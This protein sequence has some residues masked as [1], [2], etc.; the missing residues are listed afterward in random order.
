M[1]AGEHGAGLSRPQRLAAT[2]AVGLLLA[3][4]ALAAAQRWQEKRHPE[5]AR[6]KPPP[7]VEVLEL[8]A[9]P[10]GLA[11]AY[12]G[13]VEADSRAVVS[14]RLTARLVTVHHREG[15]AV[16]AGE[17]LLMLDDAELRREAERLRAVAERLA[18]ELEIAARQLER[19]RELHA[20][21]LIPDRTLDESLQRARTLEAQEREN[22]AALRLVDT[23]LGYA[24]ERAPFDGIVQRN[25]LHEGELAAIGQPLIELVSSAALKA[26]VAVPQSDATLIGPGQ[27]VELEVAALR[28]SWSAT[29]DRVY[30]AL[31]QATRNATFAAFFPSAAA[32]RPGMAVT[33]RVEL[34]ARPDAITLP[35]HAVHRNAAGAWV[36]L[37]EDGRARRRDVQPGLSRQ[38]RTLIEAGLAAGERVIVTADQRLD[39]GA[40]VSVA[41]PQAGN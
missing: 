33:A 38:G 8:R 9:A 1:N 22:R 13:T 31:D 11:R 41:E 19:D 4:V 15:A 18:G 7:A 5:P 35:A 20:R 23:R 21:K 36:W 14:A 27:P 24:V 25:Y 12:R 3:L 32:V 37:L 40:P 30:P 6:A 10:F 2:V 28:Q 26:V 16:N 29:V 17:P 34:E 39:D